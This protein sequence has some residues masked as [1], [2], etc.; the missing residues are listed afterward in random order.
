MAE[1][2]MGREGNAPSRVLQPTSNKTVVRKESRD[3]APCDSACCNKSQVLTQSNHCQQ[4]L[5]RLPCICILRSCENL[6]VEVVHCHWNYLLGCN[7][8]TWGCGLVREKV[9]PQI[10]GIQNPN[11]N[12]MIVHESF[13]GKL[14]LKT[15]KGYSILTGDRNGLHSV[16]SSNKGTPQ[17]RI[18]VSFSF[19]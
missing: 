12:H 16:Q 4:W 10:N 8:T 6:V 14:L 2:K 5:D 17:L 3:F 15:G 18:R 11:T 1:A 19:D 13:N 7:Y 9:T